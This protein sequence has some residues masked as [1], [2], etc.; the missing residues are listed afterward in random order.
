MHHWSIY[1]SL[2]KLSPDSCPDSVAIPLPSKDPGI[3]THWQRAFPNLNPDRFKALGPWQHCKVC[4][5]IV[6]EERKGS[7]SNIWGTWR[8]LAFLICLER[9]KTVPK[10]FA[11]RAWKNNCQRICFRN[12]DKPGPQKWPLRRPDN[13]LKNQKGYFRPFGGIFRGPTKHCKCGR[14]RYITLTLLV[15]ASDSRVNVND[16]TWR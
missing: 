15:L 2:I 4:N 6:E 8:K 11:A 1:W 5:E 13:L 3:C 16:E 14:D 7:R 10:L 12:P 9:S